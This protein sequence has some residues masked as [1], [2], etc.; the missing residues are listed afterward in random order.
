M[1]FIHFSDFHLGIQKGPMDK[2]T[3]IHERILD[4]IDVLESMI[5]FA[6][7]E[8]ID[9]AI[10]SGDAFHVSSPNQ[11]YLNMFAK[12]IERLARQCVVVM[13]IGNHDMPGPVHKSSSVDIFESLKIDNIII[14]NHPKVHNIETKDGMVQVAVMPYPLKPWMSDWI[15]VPANE[16]EIGKET[17]AIIQKLGDE[18]DEEFPSILAAHITVSSAKFASGQTLTLD[19]NNAIVNIESLT[20]P[21]DYVALGHIHIH[22]VLCDEPPVIY[23]GSLE[24]VD[25]GDEGHAKGFIFGNID[26]EVNWEFIE[27]DAREYVTISVDVSK[28]KDTYMKKVLDEISKH[29][30]T[31]AVVRIHIKVK[32]F[33]KILNISEIH[34]ALMDAGAFFVQDIN[35]KPIELITTPR[36]DHLENPIQS[37]SPV[38]LLDIYFE[39]Q[40][41]EDD[42]IDELLDLAEDIIKEVD[43]G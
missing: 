42:E 17:E 37:Y 13:V 29:D 12:T 40:N 5:E 35:V 36:L 8:D 23:A 21:W 11:T 30:V 24:R 15:D 16:I 41:L 20:W 9:L 18:I 32:D 34:D 1:K 43:N 14:G 27:V 19:A 33:G 26:E 22:Q 39:D 38:E 6:E 28:L 10:F 25:F 3:R 2:N 4:F 31:D 7:N